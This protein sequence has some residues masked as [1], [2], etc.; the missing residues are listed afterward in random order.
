MSERP[1]LRRSIGGFGFFSLAFGSMIGVGWIT[2]LKGMFEQAGPLG[3]TVA[4]ALGGVLM[5][6][7]GLCYAEAMKKLP[8]SGGEVAYAY[9]AF[10]TNK[11][12]IV[13]WC[14]AFGYLSVS[15]FEAVSVGIVISYIANVDAWPLYKVNG[16]VV[17]GSHLLL[18]IGFTSAVAYVNYRGVGLAARVQSIL[19]IV[20]VLGAGAFVTAGFWNGQW[21]NLQPAFG[22]PD[23]ST[24]VGGVLAVLVTA[25]FWFVGFDTIPQA[26]EERLDGFPA[27]R[28][29]Q[30]LV[31]AILG[32]TVFYA[33]VFISVGMTVPWKSIIDQPLPTAVAFQRAF[34]SPIWGRLVLVIGLIGLLTSW[35]GFFLSGCRVLFCAGTRAYHSSDFRC[36]SQAIRHAHRRHRVQR[37]RDI[38][39]RAAGQASSALCS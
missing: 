35:N 28:L 5:I 36:D 27:K 8:V 21:N 29:G 14:L 31:L 19:T 15:A 13:G 4:F 23:T 22:S 34:A 12:F 1:E 17:Y 10:G 37:D 3:T 2:G 7:I 39:R 6:S 26:A 38:C 30:M 18:A 33:L 9:K 11:A 20:L 16:S 24:A 32:S 25:P